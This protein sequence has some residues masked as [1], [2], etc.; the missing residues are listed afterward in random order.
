M[1]Q[2]WLRPFRLIFGIL[3]LLGFL[4]IFS[5][6]KAVVPSRVYTFFTSLQ[7]V[8]SILK[9]IVVHSGLLTAG[10]ILI[11]LFTL[12][13]GRVYCSFFCPLGIL[14]DFI[15]F[16]SRK[17]PWKNTKRRRFKRALN[18]LRYPILILFLVSIL[19]FG[20]LSV[21]WLD[22]YATFGRIAATMYQPVFIFLNNV[23][24]NM[25][26]FVGIYGIQPMEM[27]VF[28]A[29]TFTVSAGMFF[30]ILLMVI[31][32]D[33]LYCNT[34][35]PV[36]TLLGLL[37]RVSF[38]KIAIEKTSCTQCGKCQTACKT[39]CINIKEMTVDM[40]R[41]VSCYNCI[42]SCDDSSIVYTKRIQKPIKKSFEQSNSKREFIKAGMFFLGAYPLLAKG[43]EEDEPEHKGHGHG[44]KH[45][46]IE[47]GPISPPGSQSIQH[48]KDHCIGCQ[49]CISSCPSKVLQPAFL[50]YGFTGMMLP[51][52]DNS[53]GFCNFECTKCSEVCPTGAILPISIATKETLQ[54]G[55][56]QFRKKHCIVE[57]EGTACGSCSEHCPTQAVT[58]V[59]YKDNLTIPEINEDICVGCGACEYACP[60]TDPH[61][62]I[63]VWPQQ[64]HQVADKPVSEK[65]EVEETEDFPF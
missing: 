32:R 9:L 36:G 19:F 37:S 41:C 18:Y 10:F 47:R 57:S 58:M 59:P 16:V 25:L 26:S 30:L 2:K 54:I 8:P 14:Q 44:R 24:S 27:K 42:S 61:P 60:V 55:E 5:D 51:R 63:F 15:S 12:L 65:L 21:N 53:K 29:M 6:V 39:N 11:I 22:P 17:L 35:C 20:M 46:F 43:D 33:R 13:F 56:V 52:L 64:V 50:E 34:I 23:L 62:A 45:R 7:F 31:Y 40:S 3:F 49:L 4:I 38:L 48:L 1:T 28:S